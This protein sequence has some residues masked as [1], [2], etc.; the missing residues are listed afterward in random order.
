MRPAYAR[1]KH[2][3]EGRD[4]AA[5][6]AGATSRGRG[7]RIAARAHGVSS[8]GALKPSRRLPSCAKVFGG[9]STSGMEEKRKSFFALLFTGRGAGRV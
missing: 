6:A 7:L 9:F 2:R 3:G 1:E 4:A 8:S 5:L